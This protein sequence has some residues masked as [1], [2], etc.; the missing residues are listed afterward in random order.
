MSIARTVD[1]G[2]DVLF[3]FGR[4]NTLLLEDTRMSELDRGDFIF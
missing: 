4:G 1:D 3:N 2:D